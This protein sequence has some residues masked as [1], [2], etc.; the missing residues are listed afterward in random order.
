MIFVNIFSGKKDFILENLNSFKNLQNVGHDKNYNFFVFWN[1]NVM[2]KNE[3]KKLEKNL[4]NFYYKKVDINKFKVKYKKDFEKINANQNFSENEKNIFSKWLYQYYILNEAFKYARVK[5]GKKSENYI[6]Q[7]IRPDIYV[8]NKIKFTK[9]LTNKKI[10]NLPGAKF[11]F[12]LNDYYCIGGFENF[13]NYCKTIGLIRFLLNNSI[14]IPP[15]VAVNTQLIKTQTK[16]TI[17]RSLPTNLVGKKNNSIF[18]RALYSRE[19]GSRYISVNYS[20]YSSKENFKNVSDKL[21]Y[22][23][24]RRLLYIFVDC[25]ER[26]KIFIINTIK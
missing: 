6:W 20:K 26:S 17:N 13:K 11:G 19:K 9:I 4:D 8:P 3:Q 22:S 7:R 1:D 16:F 15:E 2:S 14:F 10:L 12:G 24:L 23:L 21:F 18:L 25:Y 5:L